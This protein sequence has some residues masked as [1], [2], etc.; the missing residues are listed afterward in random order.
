MMAEFIAPADPVTFAFRA[1]GS[2][3]RIE[4]NDTD[5]L[6]DIRVETNSAL[7]GKL[8]YIDPGSAIDEQS[9]RGLQ[10]GE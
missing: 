9:A 3:L 8:E 6:D 1:F 5:L 7:I 2:T 10:L 4:S